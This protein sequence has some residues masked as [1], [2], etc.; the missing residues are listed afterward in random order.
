MVDTTFRRV[1]DLVANHLGLD[2]AAVHDE[3]FLV[4]DL[5]AEDL[6]MLE[7]IMATEIE[8]NI[9]I[10]LDDT[11]FDKIAIPHLV[12]YIDRAVAL[13]ES[14]GRDITKDDI[15]LGR[16][17]SE[18]PEIAV[19]VRGVPEKPRFTEFETLA[20]TAMASMAEA[21]NGRGGGRLTEAAEAIKAALAEPGPEGQQAP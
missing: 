18:N 20:L 5:G 3:A 7:I 15:T 6:D 2:P 4:N 11:E 21:I 19:E 1:S 17:I 9:L 16:I 14:L 8:F 12:T 13:Q 10:F